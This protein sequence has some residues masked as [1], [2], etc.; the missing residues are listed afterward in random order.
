MHPL[1]ILVTG[2]YRSGANDDSTGIAKNVAAMTEASL[3]LS[4][5]AIC[6]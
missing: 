2:P 4:V 3:Q 1:M 5:R 6:Q